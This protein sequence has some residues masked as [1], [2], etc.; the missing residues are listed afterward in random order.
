MSRDVT[1]GLVRRPTS[2]APTSRAAEV[3]PTEPAPRAEPGGTQATTV[4]YPPKLKRA[5]K[6]RAAKQGTTLTAL[7]AAA[8]SGV[9][10]AVLVA[11]ATADP[12]PATGPR[13]AL[14]LPAGLH[15]TLK[16]TA[17]ENDTTITA[18][19]LAALLI[20]YPELPR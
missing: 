18:L 10:I 9:D 17:V 11:A 14:Y 7:V 6:V 5:L 13:S 16:L 20:A 2:T 12:A 1:A 15:R 19:I 4:A 3:L 8:V